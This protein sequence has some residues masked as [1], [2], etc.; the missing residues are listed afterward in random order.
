M[1]QSDN[2][3]GFTLFEMVVTLFILSLTLILAV[4]YAHDAY[5]TYESKVMMRNVMQHFEYLHKKTMIKGDKQIVQFFGNE[6]R[7]FS[8]QFEPAPMDRTFYFPRGTKFTKYE[9]IT[10]L[11]SGNVQAQTITL[12]TPEARLEIVFQ[13]EGGRYRYDEIKK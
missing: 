5:V 6:V 3:A 9:Q 7:F 1:K 4:P 12:D 10:L 2:K 8:N 13:L 11:P